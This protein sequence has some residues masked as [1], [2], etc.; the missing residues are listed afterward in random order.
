MNIAEKCKDEYD[1]KRQLLA[2]DE[3]EIIIGG[4]SGR[5][6]F[7]TYNPAVGYLLAT[8]QFSENIDRLKFDGFVVNNYPAPQMYKISFPKAEEEVEETKPV[9]WWK[10]W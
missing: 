7:L 4:M 1:N 2:L 6:T 8:I 3:Y 10:F 9:P 5:N